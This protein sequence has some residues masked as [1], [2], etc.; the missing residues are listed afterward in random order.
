V[1]PTKTGYTFTPASQGV[2]VN[3][4]NKTANFSS[5]QTYSISGT[6]SGGG[7][8]GATVKLTGPITATVTSNSSGAYTF[9]GLPA[10]SYTVTPTKSGHLMIPTSRSTTISTSNVTGL[11]FLSL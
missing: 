6:I 3:G 5:K 1:T 10:G 9:T 8:S 4:A 11:N 2:A 7:K